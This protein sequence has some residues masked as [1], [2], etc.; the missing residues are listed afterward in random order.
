MPTSLAWIR[1][2]ESG[3]HKS[4]ET[5]TDLVLGDRLVTLLISEKSCEIL[6]KIRLSFLSLHWQ[7]PL[8]LR[9][10]GLHFS[11]FLHFLLL[12]MSP[13]LVLITQYITR[14]FSCV[15]FTFW[16]I[17]YFVYFSSVCYDWIPFLRLRKAFGVSSDQK[18][19]T[20][21]LTASRSKWKMKAWRLCQ[22]YR[23]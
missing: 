11:L 20:E 4:P 9:H 21:Q 1:V 17:I 18:A 23:C 8:C 19:T 2:A 13:L 5:W 15:H 16:L 10:K 3:E 7:P 14:C 6:S 12:I 22:G